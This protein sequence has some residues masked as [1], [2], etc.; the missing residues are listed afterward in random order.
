MNI[1][2]DWMSGITSDAVRG[3][4]MRKPKSDLCDTILM[5]RS[6][7]LELTN[8]KNALELERDQ[9]FIR[10]RLIVNMLSVDVNHL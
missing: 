5:M 9:E 2:T 7:K 10:N 8:A 3:I 4:L 6:E 1:T